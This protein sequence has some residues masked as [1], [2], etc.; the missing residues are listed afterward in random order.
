MPTGT[1]NAPNVGPPLQHDQ[2]IHP[3]LLTIKEPHPCAEQ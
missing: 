2:H 3:F 1:S